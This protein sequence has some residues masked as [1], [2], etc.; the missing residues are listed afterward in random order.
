MSLNQYSLSTG[1]MVGR[2][3]VLNHSHQD[4]AF[5]VDLLYEVGG[6]LY[7]TVFEGEMGCT[8]HGVGMRVRRLRMICT[9]CVR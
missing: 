8:V 6:K 7:G 9:I 5:A 2:P 4:P 3:V 1:A